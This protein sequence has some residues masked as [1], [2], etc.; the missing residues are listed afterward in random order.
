MP[1]LIRRIARAAVIAGRAT[2]VSDLVS[3][4]H[5]GRW[6]ARQDQPHEYRDEPLQQGEQ[7]PAGS[8]LDDR[9]ALLR[10]LGDL[11]AQGVLSEA[12]YEQQT[13]QI[14]TS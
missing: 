7:A 14:L 8:S 2:E 6:W 11:T 13:S 10:Q 1:G 9:L 4:R 5:G 12:E 3:R